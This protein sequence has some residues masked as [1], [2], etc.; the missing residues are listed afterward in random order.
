MLNSI[1]GGIPV[2]GNLG[3]TGVGLLA[4]SPS[5][6]IG[7]RSPF[8]GMS[9]EELNKLKEWDSRPGDLQKYYE[10]Q[11]RPGPQ[12][13]FAGIPGDVGNFGGL[14][15]Q[16]LP[17]TGSAGVLGG[18]MQMG[19]PMRQGVPQGPPQPNVFS[20][21]PNM[22]YLDPEEG[23]LQFGGELNIPL[24]EK[25]RINATGTYYPET[26]SVSAT[27]TVGQPKGSPGFGIDFFVNRRLS[28]NQNTNIP[29]LGQPNLNDAGAY[30]R[31]GGRF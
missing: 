17:P 9:Q 4:G 29:G 10:Q 15:A 27:G 1:K 23:G 31:Y 30:A 22:K 12:L 19:G 16:G 20:F 5:F 6:Q 28:P 25:G 18:M 14:I 24:G 2:G 3:A 13:P 8:K 7:P 26:N 11:N 21:R